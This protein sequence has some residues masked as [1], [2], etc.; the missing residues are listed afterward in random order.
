MLELECHTQKHSPGALMVMILYLKKKA[1]C[2]IPYYVYSNDKIR[3]YETVARSS[4]GG[5]SYDVKDLCG[6]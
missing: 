1:N 3:Y 5:H 2:M 4:D 6:C